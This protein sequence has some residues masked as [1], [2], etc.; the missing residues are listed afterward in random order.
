LKKA[1]EL[2][3][4]EAQHNLTLEY[5]NDGS[6]TKGEMNAFSWLMYAGACGFLDA[7]VIMLSMQYNAAMILLNCTYCGRLKPNLKAALVEF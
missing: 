6:L 5:M 2:G 3:V 1:A 7:K 4:V